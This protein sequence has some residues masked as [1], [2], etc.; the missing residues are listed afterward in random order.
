M[1]EFLKPDDPLPDFVPARKDQAADP[2]A[3]EIFG[4]N[5]EMMRATELTSSRAENQQRAHAEIIEAIRNDLGAENETGVYEALAGLDVPSLQ[6]LSVEQQ[7][8]MGV[9]SAY[10]GPAEIERLKAYRNSLPDDRKA[11]IPDPERLEARAREIAL[12]RYTD[13]EEVARQARGFGEGAAGFAG[14]ITGAMTDPVNLA[15]MFVFRRPL[16]TFRGAV[17]YGAVT[18][19]GTEIV[20]QPFVQQYREEVGLPAGWDMGLQNVVYATIGGGAFGAVEGGLIKLGQH[21]EVRKRKGIATQI[22]EQLGAIVDRFEAGELDEAA[23]REEFAALAD[24]EP[25]FAAAMDI[26]RRAAEAEEAASANP[27][28]LSPEAVDAHQARINEAIADIAPDLNPNVSQ[29]EIEALLRPDLPDLPDLPAAPSA[30]P[31]VSPD[32]PAVPPQWKNMGLEVVDYAGLARNPERFQFKDSDA[33]GVTEAL[34]DVTQWEPE[35]AGVLLVWEAADGTRYVANGHQRHALAQRLMAEGGEAISGPAFIL[36]EADGVTAEDAMV[37]GALVNIAEGSGTS[38]DAARILRADP[39]TGKTLPP[40]SP[41]VREAKG[42]SALSDEAFGLVVNGRISPRFGAIIGRD[43]VDPAVQAQI[44]LAL[45]KLDPRTATEAASI[46]QDLQTVPVVEGKTVDLFGEA[47]FKQALIAERARVKAAVLS[48]LGR[49]KRAF[50]TLTRRADRIEAEG[51]ALDRKKNAEVKTEAVHLAERIERQAHVKGEVSDALNTAARDFAG[52]KS[53]DE[54]TEGLVN[55]LR[56]SG[57]PGGAGRAADPGGGSP[58]EP[59]PARTETGPRSR[60]GTGLQ[61]L[62]DADAGAPG[63]QKAVLA[64]QVAAIATEEFGPDVAALIRDVPATGEAGLQSAAVRYRGRIWRGAT[65]DDAMEAIARALGQRPKDLKGGKGGAVPGFVDEAGRFLTREEA[66]HVAL[67]HGQIAAAD[68]RRIIEKMLRNG[69]DFPLTTE[70]VDLKAP[71][72]RFSKSAS[73]VVSPTQLER[74]QSRFA[75]DDAAAVSRALA[76]AAACAGGVPMSGLGQAVAMTALGAGLT[77]GAVGMA[78]TYN[79]QPTRE[80]R[81]DRWWEAQPE[82]DDYERMKAAVAADWSRLDNYR[83]GMAFIRDRTEKA[84]AWYRG[85]LNRMF[86]ANQFQMNLWGQ[87]FT[88]VSSDYLDRVYEHESTRDWTARPPINPETGERYSSAVGGFQF[89]RRRW[90]Q[91]IGQHGAKY[92]LPPGSKSVDELLA[93]RTDPRW[94]TVMAAELTRSNVQVMQ[95]RLGR[96]VTQKEAY[97][98]HFMGAGKALAMIKADPS[99]NA[100]EVD[101]AGADANPNVFYKD[102]E[103]KKQPRTVGEVIALQAR[104]FTNDPAMIAGAHERGAP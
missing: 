13:A 63:T 18:S 41:L 23:V 31:A 12:Q 69:R 14:G 24:R 104:D 19:G 77:A 10:G 45:Q 75:K 46:V 20:L 22:D 50:E 16:T 102:G 81:Q 73:E 7:Q 39:E 34:R 9:G 51:N 28:G 97:L 100:A 93:L 76:E 8:R 40:R 11:L 83:D 5:I 70:Q 103:A 32:L 72:G 54:V 80:A 78:I 79:G 33:D 101:P 36:R 43:V 4:A 30:A 68:T 88:G 29:A 91:T 21:L 71:G 61:D 6:G 35:R 53:L 1:G 92:G 27:F 48:R 99:R 2:G 62:L 67:A 44:G 85:D 56:R 66:T 52:G 86:Y 87:R 49:D 25:A 55:A 90:L 57:E 96:P 84:E 26:S 95:A 15:S 74:M 60:L 37:R 82:Y 64:H 94:G 89:L 58:R 59:A 3:G 42:L 65:H 47:D 38:L 98:A 17:A